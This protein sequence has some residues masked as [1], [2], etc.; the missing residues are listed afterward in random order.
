MAKACYDPKTAVDVWKRMS[1]QNHGREVPAVI[2]THPTSTKRIQKIQHY[3]KDAIQHMP[4]ECRFELY[5]W[6]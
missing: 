3:E 5:G 4:E 2:S 6:A 1:E